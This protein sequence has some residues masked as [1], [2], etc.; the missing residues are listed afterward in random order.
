V[1]VSRDFSYCTHGN[2]IHGTLPLPLPPSLSADNQP[3]SHLHP[4]GLQHAPPDTSL[5]AT[6]WM[7]SLWCVL[8]SCREAQEVLHCCQCSLLAPPHELL[9]LRAIKGIIAMSRSCRSF[10]R[11]SSGPTIP[12]GIVATGPT[13]QQV[14]KVLVLW[15]W[16]PHLLREKLLCRLGN[17]RFLMRILARPCTSRSNRI[18]ECRVAGGER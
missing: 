17:D 16:T 4:S 6:S 14:P 18:G 11:W 8:G 13:T 10:R 2:P 12:D 7:P 3:S 9:F 1:V 5:T 15:M